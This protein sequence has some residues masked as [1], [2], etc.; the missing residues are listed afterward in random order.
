MDDPGERFSYQPAASKISA[1]ASGLKRSYLRRTEALV[2][3][4]EDFLRGNGFHSSGVHVL[5]PL[6]DFLFPLVP[7]AR[8]EARL[9]IVENLLA[10]L[11]RKLQGGF[12][13][14]FGLLHLGSEANPRRRSFGPRGS[15]PLS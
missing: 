10:L 4:R 13:N 7:E 2:K 8:I 9:Q 1:S 5:D 12:H 6:L 3:P 14:F 11:G 15:V